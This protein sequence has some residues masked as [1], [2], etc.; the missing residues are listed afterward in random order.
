VVG[1]F[2]PFSYWV[3]GRQLCAHLVGFGGRQL[4]ALKVGGWW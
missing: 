2:V 4:C 3:G 1:S